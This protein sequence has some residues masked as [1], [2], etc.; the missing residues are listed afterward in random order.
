MGFGLAICKRIVEAHNGKMIIESNLGKGTNVKI[1][2]PIM[3]ETKEEEKS[4]VGIVDS[5]A[6]VPESEV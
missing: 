2:L 5:Q 3:P 6:C 4:R 1:L